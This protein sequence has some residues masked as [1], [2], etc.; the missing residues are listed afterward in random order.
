MSP[1]DA[2]YWGL[3]WSGEHGDSAEEAFNAMVADASVRRAVQ[4]N[5]VRIIWIPQGHVIDATHHTDSTLEI[6]DPRVNKKLLQ[7]P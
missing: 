7:W 6:D 5:G 1:Q 2:A 4:G 3:D